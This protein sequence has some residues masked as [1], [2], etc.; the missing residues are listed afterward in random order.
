MASKGSWNSP[1][2]ISDDEDEIDVAG[3]LI[4]PDLDSTPPNAS[5]YPPQNHL[6]TVAEPVYAPMETNLGP[7]STLQKRKRDVA[8]A[9]PIPG[10]SRLRENRTR[11]TGSSSLETKKARK[12]RRRLEREEAIARTFPPFSALPF[13]PTLNSWG[14][15]GPAFDPYSFA[16]QAQHLPPK[17][18]LYP[19][20]GGYGPAPQDTWSRPQAYPQPQ[21]YDLGPTHDR[22]PEPSS[23]VSSMAATGSN[24]GLDFWDEFPSAPLPVEPPPPPPPP[25]APPTPRPVTPVPSPAQ[26]AVKPALPKKPVSLIIGMNPDQDRHS[27]HGTFHHSPHTITSLAANPANTEGYIPNP[28]RTIVMEQLPKTHRTRDF[29]KTWS[30]TAAG[31]HPVYFA[32]DPPS[33]K[34]LIEFATAELAR[35]AWGSPKLGGGVTGPPIKGKP[36]ADLVR[37]WW[38]RVDGVGAGAG[39]GE[40]EEGEIEGDAGEREVSVPPEATAK[41]ESKKERKARLARER[42][43]K[44]PKVQREASAAL[45]LSSSETFVQAV[46]PAE[47]VAPQ[48]PPYA[49]LPAP[50]EPYP[51]LP[52]SPPPAYSEP[53]WPGEPA[54]PD[55]V[56]GTA[57]TP[58]TAPFRPPLPPQSALGTQ[59][60]APYPPRRTERGNFSGPGSSAS[61]TAVS[62]P[63]EPLPASLPQPPASFGPDPQPDMDVDME[64]DTPASGTFPFSYPLTSDAPDLTYVPPSSWSPASQGSWSD[65]VLTTSTLTPPSAPAPASPVLGTPPLEPRAM[66]NPPKGPSFVKRSLVARHKD[67]EERIARGKLELGLKADAAAAPQPP[68]PPPPTEDAASM[69]DNLRLLVLK[70]QKSK[71]KPPAVTVSTALASTASSSATASPQSATA[72][73]VPPP[74]PAGFSLDEL[75]VSFIT[76][77]ISTLSAPALPPP[78]TPPPAATAKPL[79]QTTASLK[80]ELAAKQKRLEAHI[81]ESKTLMAQLTSARSKQEK[82]RIL[83]VMRER[84]RMM[85]E[86]SAAA[87]TTTTTQTMATTATQSQTTQTQTQK[88]PTAT[89]PTLPRKPSFEQQQQ[90][91]Q[92]PVVKLRWPESRNDVCVLIISDD[93]D[94]GSEESDGDE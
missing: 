38:Y 37:V 59:W 82:E 10:P 7:R 66:K 83:G 93:E 90:Q 61:A 49:N 91:Q 78:P 12:R 48:A 81:A 41:K 14:T 1:I 36:R 54:W 52:E 13:L 20:H 72:P 62:V 17:P 28:A 11:D 50:V 67:L 68:P 92:A 45:S 34:A 19:E 46:A 30:K 23:W 6:A 89:V 88:Q 74:A 4:H 55:G 80:Q 32:V 65:P 29:I 43:A 77:T 21:R 75:A 69:E 31:A 60:Q 86:E 27:K 40:I 26:P 94:E 47:E 8:F 24:L 57:P 70:S 42:E 58:R 25:P 35:K 33:A 39:V 22:R 16:M 18:F 9:N 44:M 51:F 71:L 56:F 63:V 85:E 76:E 5:P 64:L 79:A 53:V 84:S 2:Y 73:P 87:T 3:Q 15:T